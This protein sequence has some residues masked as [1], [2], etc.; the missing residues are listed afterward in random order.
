[1]STENK[2]ALVAFLAFVLVGLFILTLLQVLEQRPGSRLRTRLRIALNRGRQDRD[3]MRADHERAQ[4]NARRRL[5]RKN[6]GTLGYQ[7]NRLETISSGHGQRLLIIVAVI[8]VVLVIAALLFDLLPDSLLL[9]LPIMLAAPVL[10]V[11]FVY[12][13]METGFQR[14]FLDQMPDA[15]DFIVRSS[16]AGIPPNQAIRTVGEQYPKPLGPEFRRMGDSLLLGNDLQDVLDDAAL[17]INLPDFSFFTVCLLLQ[18]ETGGPLSEALDNL[19]SIIRARRDLRL[20]TRALTAEGR[21][22]SLIMSVMPFIMFGI[23]YSMNPENMKLMF[24]D[25][26]GKML[27]WIAGGMLAIGLILIRKI[28]NM[29][30]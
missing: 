18:R 21:L 10:A 14:R 25:S 12:K 9:R 6:M 4:A 17:R 5:R 24:T 20:K 19:S 30:T 28:A 16:Q 27:L 2:V 11:L 23:I 3:R 15:M 26:I 7:L 1:M 13:K 29:K 22:S 8:A